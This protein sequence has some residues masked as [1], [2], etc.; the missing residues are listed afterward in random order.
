MNGREK[1]RTKEEVDRCMLARKG[2]SLVL[3][4]S[5]FAIISVVR[6]WRDSLA[7]LDVRSS[8]RMRTWTCPDVPIRLP[9]QYLAAPASLT[10]PRVYN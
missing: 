6:R 10:T 3:I 2:A 5:P 4:S 7:S 8:L 9:T 1:M